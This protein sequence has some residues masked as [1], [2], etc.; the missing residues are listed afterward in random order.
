MY[1]DNTWWGIRLRSYSTQ[2]G[3]TTNF[4]FQNITMNMVKK[5]IDINQFNQTV[6]KNNVAWDEFAN[7]TFS[8]IK[9]SY[10]EWAG[11][12]DCSSNNVCYGLQFQNI[13]LLPISNQAQG[14]TCSDDVFGVAVN[15]TPPLTC[16]DH[17]YTLQQM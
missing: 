11:H 13:D 15:V 14:F 12:L 8:N 17:M 9:G 7:I 6:Y 5:A 1:L 10:T 16:L 2:N 3:S 4:K